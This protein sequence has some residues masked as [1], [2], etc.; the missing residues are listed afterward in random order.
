[1]GLSCIKLS[2]VHVWLWLDGHQE[3]GVMEEKWDNT[4]MSFISSLAQCGLRDSVPSDRTIRDYIK[5]DKK[6]GRERGEIDTGD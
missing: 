6:V 3:V 1:M 5:T 4:V 2:Q